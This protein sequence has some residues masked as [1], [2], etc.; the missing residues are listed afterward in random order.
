MAQERSPE[1]AHALVGD[2]SEAMSWKLAR[3]RLATPEQPRTC[4]LATTRPDGSPHLM[5][6]IGFWIE[7]AMHVVAGEVR[8]GPQP[9][10]R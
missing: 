9:G 10:R 5:P 2:G 7:G 4:W 8:E 6:V 1:R 3:E